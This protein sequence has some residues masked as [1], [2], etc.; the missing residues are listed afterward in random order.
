MRRALVGLVALA[1]LGLAAPSALGADRCFGKRANI[2]G[3]SQSETLKGTR[4]N[5]V[6]IGGDG[7][8]KI[9]G[10]GGNDLI[11]A[12]SGHDLVRG[13]AG[14]DEI[15]G[16]PGAD[17]LLGHVGND[18]LL[19]DAGGDVLI[20]AD[21]NDDMRAA[22]SPFDFL[23]GGAGDDRYDGGAGETD[24]ASL[25]EAPVGV[26][27][28][29][30]I[31]TPQNTG[32][33]LDTFIGSEGLVGSK[34]ND[35]LR[36]HDVPAELGNGIFGL[37]GSDII[38]GLD[39]NDVISGGLGDDNVGTGLDGGAG[40]DEIHGDDFGEFFVTQGG[41]DDL[42]GGEG[43]D[44]L[45]GGGNFTGPPAGDFADGG[46]HVAGDECTGV[47]DASTTECERFSRR[48]AARTTGQGPSAA[49]SGAW[50]SAFG[51]S[52]DAG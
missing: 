45:V 12:G 40:N 23:V 26:T 14:D 51:R 47:E 43:D 31:T 44:F 4:R 28:D 9:I 13:N 7:R 21:G 27:V 11:C 10:R 52:V 38:F 41:D 3:T 22:G 37:D 6:I 8:D 30:A 33:G 20:G 19:G 39:G 15:D 17:F 18:L 24:I 35:V 48:V 29:L 2:V 36:G 16:G 49:A 42:Y 50:L 25:E 46:P 32:E 1:M 5:D 34:F